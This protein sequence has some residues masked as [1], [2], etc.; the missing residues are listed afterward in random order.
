MSEKDKYLECHKLEVIEQAADKDLSAD[1]KLWN[2]GL[3]IRRIVSEWETILQG[4]PEKE[5]VHRVNRQGRNI[6]QLIGHL[7]DSAS[8]N[9]QRMVR[10]QYSPYLNFPDFSVENDMWISI[11]QHQRENWFEL[12]QLWKYFN[13]HI[14][15]VISY[16]DRSWLKNVWTDGEHEPISLEDLIFNYLAHLRLHVREISN[17]LNKEIG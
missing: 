12:L 7:I 8:N 11:Q 2:V 16:T 9:H 1:K 13:F 3:E 10:L 17:L 4:V 15:H 14:A 5:L 6:K